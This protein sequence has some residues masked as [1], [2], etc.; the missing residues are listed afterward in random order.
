MK[1]FLRAFLVIVFLLITGTG[2]FLMLAPTHPI[3]EIGYYLM[4]NYGETFLLAVGGALALIGLV[5]LLISLFPAKKQPGTVLQ[6][7]EF[8]EV[9]IT[10]S[11]LENM[12]LRVVQQ[13]RGVRG[14]SRRVDATPQ[15]LVVYL[16]L[17]VAADQNLPDLT[18]ELQRKIKEYLEE[19]TG[20]IVS[21]VRINVQSVVLDQ[22]PLKVK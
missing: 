21:E 2:I 4:H 6:N 19:S 22:V 14:S 17:K 12:V 5:S 10:L 16:Q 8:G 7:G 1:S 20:I 18:G 9:R 15:G 13:V 11:A 3:G